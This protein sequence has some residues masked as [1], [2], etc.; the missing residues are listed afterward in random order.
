MSYIFP[1]TPRQ[2]HYEDLKASLVGREVLLDELISDL[3][4][5][6][7]SE[8]LQHWMILGMRGMGKSHIITMIY[9]IVKQDED[10][11][12]AWIPVLMDEE[13]HGVFALHTLFTRIL[14]KLGEEITNIDRRKSEEIE[15][16]VNFLRDS[17]WAPDEI[18]DEVVSYLKDYVSE[19]QKRLLVLLEN[20]DDLFTKSLPKL[21]EIKKLRKILQ[22]ENF[23]LLVATSPTFFERISSSKA[24]LY[25]FF[26]IRRLDLL[27]Y[28]QSVDLLKKWAELDGRE[29]LLVKLK[30]DDYRLK[31]LYHLTGGNPRVLLFLYMAIGGQSGIE[32][33][34]NTFSKLLEEDL[35]N[36]YLSRMRDL[37]NQVQ[38]IVLAMAESDRN[39]TQAEIARRTFLPMRSIGTAMVRLENENIVR[40]ASEKKGKNTLYTLT[41]P[42]FRLW[43]QWRTSRRD[44]KV[45]ETLVEFLAIWYKRKELEVWTTGEYELAGVYS[46][47]AINFRGTRKFHCYWE[48][49][50]IEGRTFIA[51]CLDKNDYSSL[52]DTLTFWKE[53]GLE[54]DSIM[55]TA[56]EDI[57]KPGGLEEAE[58]YF[59]AK[60]ESDPND[61]ETN[62]TLG[63]IL[64]HKG[65]YLRAEEIFRRALGLNPQDVDA[66][67][68]L[69]HTQLHLK[70]YAEA[71]EAFK[72]TLKHRPKDLGLW[73]LLGG[74]R[75][76]QKNYSGAEAAIMQALE[77]NPEDTATWEALGAVRSL[78]DNHKG[79]EEAFVHAVE[80]NPKDTEALSNLAVSRI[81]QKDFVGAEEAYKRAVELDPKNA[82]AW[83]ELG[84]ARFHNGKY[85][86]AEEACMHALKL[87]PKNDLAWHYLGNARGQQKKYSAAEQAFK[88]AIEIN[89]ENSE[90]WINLGRIRFEQL[91]YNGA[92]EACKRGLEIDPEDL[93]GWLDLGHL[94]FNQ[95]DFAGAEDALKRALKLDPKNTDAWLNL[96]TTYF[97]KENY[98]G[99]EEVYQHL[100]QLK[101]ND[102]GAWE[103]LAHVRFHQGNYSGVEEACRQALELDPKNASAWG[104]L[105]P[106]LYKKGDYTGGE[107]AL[108]RATQ[109]DPKKPGAWMNIAYWYFKDFRFAEA[110]EGLMACIR[111]NDK[112]VHAYAGLC[113]LYLRDS[114]I[115]EPFVVF[116]RALSLEDTTDEFKSQL[117]FFRAMIYLHNKNITPFTMDLQIVVNLLDAIEE[118]KRRTLIGELIKFL[119]GTT[120]LDNIEEIRSYIHALKELAPGLA[121][122]ISPFDHV[123]NYIGEYF[124]NNKHKQ[125]PAE[126]AQRILDKLPNELRGPV[127]EMVEEVKRNILWWERRP[128]H[129]Q[130]EKEGK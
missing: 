5:Q 95:G 34:V 46:K 120:F 36:Y 57:D 93:R 100:Q 23:L 56:I 50:Q 79:A 68:N 61:L 29:D 77:L 40:P 22:H 92:E 96:A 12:S 127:E 118:E 109:L 102:A 84:H 101:P 14:I 66:W 39:L 32:S 6:R 106:A 129:N 94:R 16:K 81:S 44:R 19:S 82:E 110:A 51:E 113:E 21:N 7:S 58:E 122:V 41:D 89:P 83:R 30:K 2:A 63:R 15:A 27:N 108:K 78:Q 88:C 86:E 35:S 43:Y 99:A 85:P 54:T 75:G 87:D 9:Y 52:F 45:I 111:A 90:A 107:E 112:F 10:L 1:Y 104:F 128:K 70:K 49:F 114:T 121:S 130:S 115:T 72:E 48:G 17:N 8:T 13:E 123:L 38:P 33:A 11:S 18:L 73:V 103:N 60:L 20:A 4:D 67:L 80:L 71:E 64:I 126:R 53:C 69:G 105:G 117:H 24:P 59:A 65:E 55:E 28:K 47:E 37:S 3:K 62:L 97:R 125:L 31:V 25:Q 76:L 98:A 116:E 119:V 91:N 42:L 124:S 74:M 26:R